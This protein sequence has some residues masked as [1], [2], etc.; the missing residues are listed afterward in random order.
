MLLDPLR[1]IVGAALALATVTFGSEQSTPRTELPSALM[2]DVLTSPAG[3]NSYAPQLTV[4]GSRVLLSWIEMAGERATVKF[5]ER[6]NTGWSEPRS[7]ASGD[8]FFVNASD[9]PSVRALPD[10]TLAAHWL[11]VNGNNPEGYD[12][13]LSWSK[14]GGRTWS[15]P[16]TPHHDKTETQHGFASLFPMPDGGLGLVWLD[17]RTTKP[18]AE[19]FGNMAL[20]AAAFTAS[21]KQRSE[22]LVD[23]RVCDCCPTA[24]ALT[25]E[26][27]VVAYRNRS[28][29]DIRDIYV[30]RLEK[31]RWAPATRVHRDNWKIEA[32][33]V[34]GPSLSAQGRDVAVAWFTVQKDQGQALVAFSRDAG[35]TFGPARRIDDVGSTGH[36]GIQM[37]PDG[38]AA[39]S[40]VEFAN[41]RAQFQV[42]VVQPDGTRSPAVT[43][44]QSG[45]MRIPRLIRGRDELLFAWSDIVDG[46]PRVRTARAALR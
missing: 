40:W 12:L 7:V 21:G 3:A 31:G 23:S 30:A 26:G 6:T 22:T 28:A 43:M 36:V 11:Q 8:N 25:S 4:E 42:R 32:C 41:K 13:R 5:A 27:V 1:T 24:T 45:G 39:V 18:E 38:S 37:L 15:A 33:P 16:T 34:N 29:D 35:R 46:S 44:A 2:P 19:D 10:G 9:V 20:R 14:D 17:G